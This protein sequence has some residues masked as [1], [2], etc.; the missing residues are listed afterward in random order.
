MFSIVNKTIL[1]TGATGY[2]GRV[3]SFEL[4]KLGAKIL[5]NSRDRTSCDA[6]VQQ[7]V[8]EGGSAETASFDVTN[9][10]EIQRVISRL[11]PID[12]IVNNAYSGAGGTLKSSKKEE[13]QK[14]YDTSLVAAADLVRLSLPNLRMAVKN[15][16]Y[17]SVI[18]ISSMYGL[19]SP[20][21]AIYPDTEN[22]NP[23]F[24]GAAKA[25]LIQWTKYAACELAIESI[26]VNSIAPGPFPSES[27]QNN[28]PLMVKKIVQKV[29]MKRIGKPEELVGPV[30]F[31]S[32]NASSF[33]TGSNLTVDGGWTA[34]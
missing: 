13:Y 12:V 8:A 27:T 25:A 30:T 1:I 32:S 3:L 31:L 11:G 33:M 17:A 10:T 5:I 18:N 19:V 28:Q 29:P 2:L 14:S 26:R 4:A 22:T 15:S 24:Y 9:S 23:P 20:D 16:G 7:I 6:L 21:I 34:W